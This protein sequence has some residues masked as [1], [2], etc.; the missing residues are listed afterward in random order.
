MSDDTPEDLLASLAARDPLARDVLAAL[1]LG[2]LARSRT[3]VCELLASPAARAP[4]SVAPSMEQTR[5]TLMGLQRAGLANEDERR[6]GVWSMPM[7]LSPAVYA[8]LLERVPRE[9]LRAALAHADGYAPS[10]LTAHGHGRFPTLNAAISRIRLDALCGA[11]I[12]ELEVLINRLPPGLHD[13]PALL[14][15]AIGDCIDEAL[16]DRLHAQLQCDVL[17]G[18][19]DRLGVSLQT[20]LELGAAFVRDRAARLVQADATP[21]THALRWS[22]AFDRLLA[23]GAERRGP[24]GPS[25]SARFWR[26]PSTRWTPASSRPCARRRATASRHARPPR[27]PRRCWAGARWPRPSARPRWRCRRAGPTPS[28]SSTPRSRPC[29]SSPASA[30]AWCRR[31]WRSRTRWRCW[32]SRRR[33]ISTRR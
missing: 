27:R 14:D 1:A 3:W 2:G 4:G 9:G 23:D 16:F 5:H 29:A 28:P 20:G 12:A 31:R 33:R 7:N 25:R 19:L 21:D 8:D 30:A 32:R 10:A 11:A 17:S 26:R 6:A 24:A 22:L 13:I 15:A 18:A